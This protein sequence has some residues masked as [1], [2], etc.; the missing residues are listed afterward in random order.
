MVA[1]LEVLGDV[2]EEF[3]MVR[4]TSGQHNFGDSKELMKDIFRLS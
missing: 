3:A 2:H 4:S 1:L